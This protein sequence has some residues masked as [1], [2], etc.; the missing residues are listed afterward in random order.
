MGV[1]VTLL[2]LVMS[3]RLLDD[4]EK[5]STLL[6]GRDGFADFLLFV[7][8]PALRANKNFVLKAVEIK[9]IALQGATED[10]KN[11]KDIVLAAVKQDCNAL[12]FASSNLQRDQ[13]ILTA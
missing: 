11:D 9:G 1:D 4:H 8:N 6:P 7:R 3:D 2:R 13:E 10:L 12:K 5:L